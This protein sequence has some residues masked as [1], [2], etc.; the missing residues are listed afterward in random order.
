MMSLAATFIMEVF[1]ILDVSS[2]LIC[3]TTLPCIFGNISSLSLASRT[4]VQCCVGGGGLSYRTVSGAVCTSC[5]G[6]FHDQ[7]VVLIGYMT[8]GTS[9]Y[10]GC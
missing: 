5:V 6:K 1:L 8:S 7:H 9:Y 2:R 10:V 4:P 3:Y